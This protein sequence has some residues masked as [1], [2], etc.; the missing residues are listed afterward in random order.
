[1]GEI[2][3][4]FF[5][6]GN[7]DIHVLINRKQQCGFFYHIPSNT[8]VRIR[9]TEYEKIENF[10]SKGGIDNLYKVIFEQI[11]DSFRNTNEKIPKHKS[12]IETG[13]LNKCTLI[14]SS[15]CNLSCAYCY[16]NKG[17][18]DG[19]SGAN[20]SPSEIVFFFN[21]LF[22][23]GIRQIDEVMFFGGEP[24]LNVQAII[25]TCEL[26]KHQYEDKKISRIPNYSIITNLTLC[27]EAALKVIQ[28]NNIRVT[29]SIDG[30]K[31]IHDMQRCY[32]NGGGSFDDVFRNF[33]KA[34]PYIDS[35]EATYTINHLTYHLS[36]EMLAEQLSSI[37]K[38]QKNHIYISDVYG[39]PELEVGLNNEKPDFQNDKFQQED[40]QI[41][42]AFRKEMQSDLLCNAGIHSICLT[43]DGD[44]FPC[45][46]FLQNKKYRMGNI[47][48]REIFSLIRNSRLEFPKYGKCY[49]CWARKICHVCVAKYLNHT[50]DIFNEDLCKFRRYC[51]DQFLMKA[52]FGVLS[53]EG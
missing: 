48:D 49:E 20:M 17:K 13:I 7:S 21:K 18:Y 12:F 46:M 30:P 37:L 31:K 22:D 14:V 39:V 47:H 25:S 34:R 9:N 19:L 3:N 44:I 23:N 28:E 51:Y 42:P 50:E 11:G 41:L 10:V 24:L 38:I 26:F 40:Y 43:P 53:C 35:V 16:A 5:V 1:M 32:S 4:L 2:S 27:S 45:H 52:V 6:S 15:S 29:A 36:K 33:Q 8:V